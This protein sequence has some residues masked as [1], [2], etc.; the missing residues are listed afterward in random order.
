MQQDFVN[1]AAHELRTPIQ[2]IL[3][4][5]GL[6]RTRKEHIKEDELEDSL[7]LINRNALRLKRLSE[8]IL[9][10][11]RIG[12]KSLKLK[13]ERLNLPDVISSTI[14][15]IVKNQIDNSMKVQVMFEPQ[16][17][18]IIFIEAD[19]SRLTQVISN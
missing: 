13:R 15:D 5:V 17:N 14:Q 18:D 12:S 19:R 9:D 10:V 2:P 1:L 16:G 3:G 8:D 11:T 6:L 4:L 7:E